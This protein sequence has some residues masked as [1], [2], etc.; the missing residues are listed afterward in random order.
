MRKTKKQLEFEKVSASGFEQLKMFCK[1]CHYAKT[2]AAFGGNGITK[3]DLYDKGMTDKVWSWL[4]KEHYCNEQKPGKPLWISINGNKF[5]PEQTVQ[6]LEK[7]LA[8]YEEKV[9]ANRENDSG[10]DNTEGNGS[11]Q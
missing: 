11:Q 2:N 4:V 9:N 7:S 10:T 6:N 3:K 8:E 5:Y 1:M